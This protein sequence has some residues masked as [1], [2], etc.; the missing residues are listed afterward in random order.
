[1]F[2]VSLTKK[3][4]PLGSS[5]NCYSFQLKNTQALH[6]GS[7][8]LERKKNHRRYIHLNEGSYKY[9]VSL[10]EQFMYV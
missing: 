2:V 3:T 1:M 9:L 7:D 10:S 5:H 6:S 4:G 8:I